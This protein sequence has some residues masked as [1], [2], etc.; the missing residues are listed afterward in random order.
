MC[1]GFGTQYNGIQKE[2]KKRAPEPTRFGN[3][4][5]RKG[6]VWTLKQRTK[7]QFSKPSLVK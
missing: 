3:G 5:T 6:A 7:K 4:V 2:K 1:Q